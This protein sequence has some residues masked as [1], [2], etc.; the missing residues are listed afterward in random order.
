MLSKFSY[1]RWIFLFSVFVLCSSA[2]ASQNL[3][4]QVKPE[5]KKWL[6]ED[7]RWIIKDHERREFWTLVT[8]DERDR[9]VVQFWERRNPTP[10]S[11][12]N[13]FKQE[14]YRRIAYANE[15][16]AATVPGWKSDRGRMYIVYGPPDWIDSH[17]PSTDFRPTYPFEDNYPYKVWH[18]W[19]IDGWGD[20][21]SVRF[22]DSCLCGEFQ[23]TA[24]P[25]AK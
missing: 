3:R 4:Q 16:F 6:D 23:L 10:G 18:Y 21:V 7:V 5:Y 17:S 11:K 8:D 22:V 20:G 2:Y 13:A 12:E 25:Q 24:E 9:F 19:H 1:N 15:H 14:H